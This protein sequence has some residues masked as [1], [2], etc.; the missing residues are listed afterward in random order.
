MKILVTN[1]CEENYSSRMS[2]CSDGWYLPYTVTSGVKIYSDKEFLYFSTAMKLADFIE[3]HSS[4]YEDKLWHE[5]SDNTYKENINIEL[6][7]EIVK[8]LSKEKTVATNNLNDTPT[9]LNDIVEKVISLHNSFLKEINEKQ[10]LIK[11]KYQKELIACR[12]EVASNAMH[13]S[14]IMYALDELIPGFEEY[15]LDIAM[16]N[17]DVALFDN[18]YKNKA[19]KICHNAEFVKWLCKIDRFECIETFY[20]LNQLDFTDFGTSFPSSKK[21]IYEVSNCII[22]YTIFHDRIDHFENFC[23]GNYPAYIAFDP[24]KNEIS[25]SKISV[26]SFILRK[27]PMTIVLHLIEN[28]FNFFTEVFD[29]PGSIWLGNNWTKKRVLISDC[30]FRQELLS[31]FYKKYEPK[32]ILYSLLYW[33]KY[34]LI[35]LY[36]EEYSSGIRNL[37]H[38]EIIGF[39]KYPEAIQ[40]IERIK[41]FSNNSIASKPKRK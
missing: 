28:N 11:L 22:Y 33:K 9:C 40:Y 4:S 21:E 2:R 7:E 38:Y 6:T 3:N 41:M 5:T 27:S 14:D 8:L 24:I 39:E 32:D 13:S 29:Y 12:L 16:K 26:A 10:N 30:F 36:L 25:F 20:D 37:S 19:T 23:N 35:D 17:N 15:P 1:F 18:L 34:D 31:H